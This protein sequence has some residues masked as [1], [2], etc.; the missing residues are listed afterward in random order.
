MANWCI[1]NGFVPNSS[2]IEIEDEE[3]RLVC[4]GDYEYNVA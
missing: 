1:K 2:S 4:I 3:G